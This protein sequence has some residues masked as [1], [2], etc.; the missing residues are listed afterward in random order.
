[1]PEYFELFDARKPAEM[2]VNDKLMMVV[3]ECFEVRA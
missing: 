1:M 3:E 2:Y